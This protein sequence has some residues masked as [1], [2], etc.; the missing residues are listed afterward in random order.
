MIRSVGLLAIGLFAPALAAPARAATIVSSPLTVDVT[1]VGATNAY[2]PLEG[3]ER[4]RLFETAGGTLQLRVADGP[5]AGR[6]LGRSAATPVAGGPVQRVGDEQVQ[7]TTYV[8]EADGVARFRVRQTTG[9]R[10][11]DMGYRVAYRVENLAAQP[12]RFRAAVVGSLAGTSSWV[13]DYED[14]PPSFLGAREWSTGIVRGLEATPG[15][16]WTGWQHGFAGEVDRWFDV[17]PTIANSSAYASGDDLTAVAWEDHWAVGDGLAAGATASYGLRWELQ[18]GPQIAIRAPVFAIAGSERPAVVEATTET[19]EPLGG[20]SLRVLDW[21]ASSARAATVTTDGAGRAQLPLVGDRTGEGHVAVWLDQDGDGALGPTEPRAVGDTEW[22]DRLVVTPAARAWT[23]QDRVVL[24]RLRDDN[25]E[26]MA[27]QTVRWRIEGLHPRD[28]VTQSNADGETWLDLSSTG[29][30]SDDVAVYA[31]L[32]GDA[33]RDAG[34]PAGSS[35]ATWEAPGPG[36]R[37]LPDTTTPTL[38]TLAIAISVRSPDNGAAPVSRLSWRVDGPNADN[39]AGAAVDG[40]TSLTL[41]GRA[42]GRDTLTVSYDADGDGVQEPGEPVTSLVVD[43]P[44]PSRFFPPVGAAL[45]PTF[46]SEPD[47]AEP[48]PSGGG[49]AAV[50]AVAAGAPAPAWLPPAARVPRPRVGRVVRTGPRRV[51]VSLAC[52]VSALTGCRGH[53]SLWAARRVGRAR[54][55]LRAGRSRWVTVRTRTRVRAGRRVLVGVGAGARIARQIHRA[56]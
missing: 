19:G 17:E 14:G 49:F 42:A 11:G 5:L 44:L 53:V 8:L 45:S 6:T 32:D 40:L 48:A 38:G 51:K 29:A 47:P 52:P 28:L 1:D 46:S 2:G 21:G 12:V 54:Y 50:P 37:L 23:G 43:W 22:T 33:E 27:S 55:S 34:E 10:D 7:E 36:L 20:T 24:A 4:R 41:L 9:V 3:A 39:G 26:V 30:G 15:H 56:R 13:A 35:R 16:A 18:H 25:G 31:D